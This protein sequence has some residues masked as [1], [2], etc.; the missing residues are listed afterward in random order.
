MSV[1][2]ITIILLHSISF[3]LPG[4]LKQ[5]RTFKQLMR[6]LIERIELMN[7]IKSIHYETDTET[8]NVVITESGDYEISSTTVKE[9][10]N[11]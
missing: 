6:Y 3:G 7:I 5:L 4:I 11:A 9:E 10:A 1:T 8:H 2:T